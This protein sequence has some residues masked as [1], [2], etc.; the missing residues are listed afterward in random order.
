[1]YDPL[2]STYSFP[3]PHGRDAKVPLSAFRLLERLPGAAHPAVYSV[4]F[5]CRCGHD[6]PGLVS[7]DEL[8]T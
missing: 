8:V 6:H 3:C 1:M 4:L 7:H 5:A 2:T